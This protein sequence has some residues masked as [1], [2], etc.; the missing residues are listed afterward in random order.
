MSEGCMKFIIPIIPVAQMRARVTVRGKH[1][2][3]YKTKKQEQRE[4]TLL[5]FLVQER[6]PAPLEGPLLLGVRAFLPIPKSMPK[7]KRALALSGELRPTTKPDLD[8]LIKHFKDCAKELLW[9]DDKQVVGYLEG[10]G[11]Y[12][13][14]RPRWEIEVKEASNV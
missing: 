2:W 1:A 11:K 4:A 14:D 6:P 13:S 10:T 7:F 9:R 12:Y 5:A 3:A 8:N